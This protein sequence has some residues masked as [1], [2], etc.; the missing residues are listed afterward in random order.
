M[1]AADWLRLVGKG[2]LTMTP[3]KAKLEERVRLAI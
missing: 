3:G 1:R 2:S